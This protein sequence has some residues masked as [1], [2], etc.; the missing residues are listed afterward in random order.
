MGG[1]T[2]N[3]GITGPSNSLRLFQQAEA[4][5]NQ[6][7]YRDT[8]PPHSVQRIESM[9]AHVRKHP[10]V[11]KERAEQL[12][13]AVINFNSD[14]TSGV[15]DPSKVNAI[16]LGS[17]LRT[18]GHGEKLPLIQETEIPQDVN[19][20]FSA[21]ARRIKR[22]YYSFVR[23]LK[24]SPNKLM[25]YMV[26]AMLVDGYGLAIKMKRIVENR[27]VVKQDIVVNTICEEVNPGILQDEMYE[28]G[29]YDPKWGFSPEFC[30]QVKADYLRR[31]PVEQT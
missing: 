15:F 27:H 22:G 6:S 9:F 4:Y 23:D 10:E 29:W 28:T 3:G 21:F 18:L 5:F 2:D 26:M 25:D 13:Q 31:H 17:T 12:D 30:E 14:Q 19:K 24:D 11:V 20:F 16:E 1:E 8:L 7:S